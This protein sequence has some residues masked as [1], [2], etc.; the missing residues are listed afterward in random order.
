MIQKKKHKKE[1]HE[2]TEDRGKERRQYVA[3]SSSSRLQSKKD[4][5]ENNNNNWS[6]LCTLAERERESEGAW[7]SLVHNLIKVNL[8][9][10]LKRRWG[11]DVAQLKSLKN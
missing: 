6:H 11:V 10:R 7:V 4:R 5:E 3:C 2:Q 8:G 9:W 1:G